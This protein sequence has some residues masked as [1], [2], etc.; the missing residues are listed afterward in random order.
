MEDRVDPVAVVVAFADAGRAALTATLIED[1][2]DLELVGRASSGVEVLEL[3]EDLVPD[4]VLLEV[5][6]P[7]VDVLE[8]VRTLRH[9]LPVVRVLPAAERL[10]A[11]T[12]HLLLEG[13]AGG[14]SHAEHTSPI[15]SVLVGVARREMLLPQAWAELAMGDVASAN[16]SDPFADVLRLT[17]TEREVLERLTEGASV[18]ELAGEYKVTPRLVMLHIGYIVS[19]L[20][21]HASFVHV[22][23]SVV[24]TPPAP[25]SSVTQ[26]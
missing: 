8:L 22:G 2:D 14:L 24:R 10:D 9:E 19:K 1:C 6:N 17:E 25:E 18:D 26:F 15:T 16:R 20:Q 7:Q 11:S 3:A 12:Y 5:G 13:A 4:V 21:R 23:A